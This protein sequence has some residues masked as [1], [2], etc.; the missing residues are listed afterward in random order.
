MESSAPEF[1]APSITALL[2]W[3]YSP[4]N[5]VCVGTDCRTIENAQP[6]ERPGIRAVIRFQLEADSPRI[7]IETL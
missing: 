5:V 4:T 1:E 3:R 6:V 7:G 2:R